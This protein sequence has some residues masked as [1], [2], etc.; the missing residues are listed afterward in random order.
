MILRNRY[1]D[2][3]SKICLD[4]NMKSKVMNRIREVDEIRVKADKKLTF[5][6]K[7]FFK[8][9]GVIAACCAFIVTYAVTIKYPKLTNYDESSKSENENT[10]NI[11]EN[12][13]EIEKDSSE[14]IVKEDNNNISDKINENN[15]AED[16]SKPKVNQYDN[17]KEN[18][19]IHED[20]NKKSLNK[21]N[22]EVVPT[23]GNQM[24]NNN[25]I[26][27]ETDN[28]SKSDNDYKEEEKLGNTINNE[29]SSNAESITK[30]QSINDSEKLDNN[31]IKSASYDNS[32]QNK[33][34]SE[35]N[36][37]DLRDIGYHVN[38]I[39]KMSENEI[40]IKYSNDKNNDLSIKISTK[41]ENDVEDNLSNS[42]EN[43]KQ[44]TYSDVS[45]KANSI[46]YRKDN[47]I[48]YIWSSNTI[49]EKLISNIKK[50]I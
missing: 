37:P 21:K 39:N 6:G 31:K 14:A 4:D 35:Y 40:E 1:K 22:N 12:K 3:M 11:Q 45:E 18:Y 47:R 29:T 13:N 23:E 36:A 26:I 19:N 38:Y 48:Y 41:K 27:N 8:Y 50:Y 5:K 33:V 20:N 44:K 30:N 24:Q 43:D 9:S 28:S 32:I 34:L 46:I 25:I 17:K 2:Q 7:S 42:L 16:S 49:D 15:V 10:L